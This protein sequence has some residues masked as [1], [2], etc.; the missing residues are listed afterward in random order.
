MNP[1]EYGATSRGG[2]PRPSGPVT[3]WKWLLMLAVVLVV[4]AVLGATLRSR[5]E[6]GSKV[7]RFN[8]AA[9][10]SFRLALAELD[11]AN[12][13]EIHS[14]GLQ[15][16]DFAESL[17]ICRRLSLALVGSTM[18]LEEIRA[19]EQIAPERR[20]SWW[21]EHLLAD[22]R[23]S[24]YFSQRIARA[25]VGTHQGPFLLFRRRKFN[26]WLAQ[27]LDEDVPYDEI[28]RQMIASEGLWTDTPAVNFVT[29]TMDEEQNGRADPVRLAGRTSRAFLAMRMD[30]LQCHDDVLQ[31]TNFGTSAAPREGTQH[32]FHELAAFYA[33]AAAKP[34]FRGIMEDDQ[35]YKFKYL[36]EPE[37][38]SV[39]PA[40]PFYQQLLPDKGKPRQRLAAWVTHPDNKAF[41][42]ASVN[43]T[44]ALMFGRA[45]VEP[46]DDIPLVDELPPM[47]DL[48]ADDF[49][50]SGFNMRR[51]VALIAHTA[52]FRRDSRADF[53]ITPE[54]EQHWACFPLVQLRPDQVAGSISQACRLTAIDQKS[55]IFVQLKAF[56]DGQEFVKRFGDRGEDEFDSDP[57]TITQRLLMMNG[58]MIAERTKVDLVATAGTR[59][60]RFI[61]RDPQAVEAVF[62]SVLNRYPTELEREQF[63]AHLA[64]KGDARAQAIADMTWSMLNTTEFSWNH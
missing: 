28:V 64:G 13:R 26:A 33:G 14:A 36:N 5:P 20:V 30:C 47:L 51:L 58:N 48:L 53:E 52:A 25:C 32:D 23:W 40:V 46:V 50:K 43:R 24:D 59:I 31:K 6:I 15:A 38:V 2:G 41:A 42:R 34:V 21:V 62:L 55:F 61:D 16:T 60:A 63:V 9:Q 4:A 22:Q 18:S 7:G 54:H 45:L 44:W 49:A 11:A 12:S 57:I 3:R 37:E 8:Y 56:G 19:L 1:A 27:Q 29:A 35:A 39:A 10:P 17:T